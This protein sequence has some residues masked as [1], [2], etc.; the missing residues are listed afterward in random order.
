MFGISAYAQSPYAALGAQDIVLALTGVSASGSVGSVTNGGVVVALTGVQAVGSVG[1]VGQVLSFALTGVQATGSVGNMVAVYWR[2][3][4]DSQNAN[5]QNITD[6]QTPG[7][8]VINDNQT[9]TWVKI[10]TVP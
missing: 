4:D 10:E 6:S 7:W 3:V 8:T 5:W 9:T 1:S 2:L